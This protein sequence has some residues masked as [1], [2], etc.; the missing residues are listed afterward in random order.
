MFAVSALLAGVRR[1][2]GITYDIIPP[3]PPFNTTPPLNLYYFDYLIIYS[4]HPSK[5]SRL[6]IPHLNGILS[7]SLNTNKITD[8]ETVKTFLEGYLSIGE[9]AMDQ[10]VGYLKSSKYFD[11]K[12]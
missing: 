9:W 11:K 1:S 12:R 5:T 10:S 3:Q 6:T 4:D 2:T 8:S 7:P